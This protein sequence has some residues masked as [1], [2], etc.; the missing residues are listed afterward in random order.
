ME[1]GDLANGESGA[2]TGNLLRIAGAAKFD[3]RHDVSAPGGN[4]DDGDVVD[5]RIRGSEG[6][7]SWAGPRPTIEEW[8]AY[9]AEYPLGEQ[10]R[11]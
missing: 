3:K 9:I 1:N 10:E 2:A 4:I 5:N 8:K 6:C 7:G 11:G